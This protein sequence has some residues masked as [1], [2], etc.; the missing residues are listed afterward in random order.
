MFAVHA[1]EVLAAFLLAAAL[2]LAVAR[3]VT[4]TKRLVVGAILTA[5]LGFGLGLEADARYHAC[6]HREERRYPLGRPL[7]ERRGCEETPW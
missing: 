7:G 3:E 2:V 6:Q 4:W 1:F 5:M